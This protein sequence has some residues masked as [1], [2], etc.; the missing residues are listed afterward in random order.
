MLSGHFFTTNESEKNQII[1]KYPP[2]VWTYED[3]AFYVYPTSST[4]PNTMTVARFW[5]PT[6]QHHFYTANA[7]ER[8]VVK[9]SYPTS[10]WTYEGDNFRVPAPVAVP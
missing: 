10:I 4:V 3:I 8:E 6:N 1:A 7:S 2:S 5:S 9:R